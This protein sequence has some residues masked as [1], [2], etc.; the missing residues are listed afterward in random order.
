MSETT[1]ATT[2]VEEKHDLTVVRDVVAKYRGA[3]GSIIPVLQTVQT[4]FGYLPMEAVELI[5]KSM[6]LPMAQLLGVASFY[7]QFRL[8]PRGKYMVKICCGT[9][10]HVKG[11]QRM[12]E[13]ALETLDVEAGE[14]TADKVFTIERVACI[15]ACSLAPVITVNDDATGYLDVDKFAGIIDDLKKSEKTGDGE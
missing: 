15:G 6:R 9:A 8:T 5:S 4:H 13:R 10:C 2:D 1:T 11:A 7:A 12:V 14:T 3:R